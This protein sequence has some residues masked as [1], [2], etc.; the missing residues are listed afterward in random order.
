MNFLFR[1]LDRFLG[2]LGPIL[3]FL[4]VI[5]F[6]AVV[7]FLSALD[8]AVR[9]VEP[10]NRRMDPAQVWLNLI[11][12]FNV[13]WMVVTIERVGESIRNEFI[14]RGHHKKTESYGKTAGITSIILWLVGILTGSGLGVCLLI[15][16]FF[17]FMY[18]VVYWAQISGYARRLKNESPSFSVPEDE[19]W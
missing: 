2:E 16:W 3:C 15:F 19:G 18:W 4:L 9:Q 13:I 7:A 12:L 5:A 17:A 8:R 1:D 10:D 6:V 14:S 11:P